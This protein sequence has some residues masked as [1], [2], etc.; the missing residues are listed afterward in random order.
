MPEALQQVRDDLGEQA[1]ILNTRTLRR[2][3]RFNLAD[4]ARVEVTAAYDEVQTVQSSGPA[5]LAARKYGAQLPTPAPEEPTALRRQITPPNP[6]TQSPKPTPSPQPTSV[7]EGGIVRQLRRLQDTVTRL[8]R[9]S[10]VALPDEL[11]RLRERLASVRLAADLSDQVVGQLLEE[12]NG[13]ALTDRRQVGENA[14]AA[15]IQLLPPSKRIKL[16]AHR[17]VIGFFGASGVGKT[18]A[19]AKI[20]AGF[21][22]K[23]KEH[24]L[25]VTTDDQRV[26][27]RDQVDTF[28]RIIGVPLEVAHE[29][30]EM[31][32]VLARHEA[33]RLVLI[34]APGCGPHDHKML[35]HQARLFAAAEVSEVHIVIDALHGLDHMLDMLAVSGDLPERR[36]LFAK[37]DE[38]VRPGPVLSAAI[39]SQIPTSYLAVGAR[40]PGDIEVGN[41]NQLVEQII[42]YGP[43]N[44]K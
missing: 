12:M 1:V 39:N 33:A 38:M 16:T 41:L 10:G 2:N 44:K 14:A 29:E 35:G 30:D 4:E 25:L 13:K 6:A 43:K 5:Q 7:E 21:I 27:A 40:V 3:N 42:G 37:M 26:G 28:A 17:Q 23:R 24:I 22:R 15:L 34:D 20:A 11:A 8:E 19:A 32:Q 9:K 36:L 31:R 18:T